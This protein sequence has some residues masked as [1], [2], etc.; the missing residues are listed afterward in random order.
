MPKKRVDFERLGIGYV[1]CSFA[2]WVYLF[3]FAITTLALLFLAS[4]VWAYAGWQ[5]TEVIQAAIMIVCSWATVRVAHKR[6]E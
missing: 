6:S 3:A 4:A 5:G 2:G 1:P